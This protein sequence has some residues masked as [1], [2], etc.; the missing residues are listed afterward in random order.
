MQPPHHWW[1]CLR[2]TMASA[3]AGPEANLWA[4]PLISAT[5]VRCNS[6]WGLTQ[7]LLTG[8]ASGTYP[9]HLPL[10][11]AEMLHLDPGKS[12][13]DR[14]MCTAPKHRE[15]KSPRNNRQHQRPLLHHPTQNGPRW[16][17]LSRLREPGEHPAPIS[18]SDPLTNRKITELSKNRKCKYTKLKMI[19]N[20]GTF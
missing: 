20:R 13:L 3:A 16:E 1:A 11:A 4:P 8:F 10:S 2:Q 18:P 5:W 12:A 19:K 6:S 15:R 14:S 7:F 17:A 9:P